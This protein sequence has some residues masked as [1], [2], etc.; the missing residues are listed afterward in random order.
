MEK[1]KNYNIG[2]GEERNLLEQPRRNMPLW[3]LLSILT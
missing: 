2:F 1:R 3:M